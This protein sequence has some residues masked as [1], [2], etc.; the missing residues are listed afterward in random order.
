MEDKYKYLVYLICGALI[1]TWLGLPGAGYVLYSFQYIFEGTHYMDA[2]PLEP[3]SARTVPLE[4]VAP[5]IAP[6][7]E[8][9]AEP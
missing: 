7:A 9:P 2:R 6:L 5:I 1:Y 8:S 4:A 3:F